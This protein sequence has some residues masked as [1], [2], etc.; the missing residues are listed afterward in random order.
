MSKQPDGVP[1]EL[2]DR[3]ED[4]GPWLWLGLPVGLTA[5][6]WLTPLLGQR[7]WKALMMG[8]SGFLEVATVVVLVAAMIVCGLLLARRR[9]LPRGTVWVVLLLGLASLFYAGEEASWGQHWLGYGT[10]RAVK[11]INK[12]EEFNLHNL[13]GRYHTLFNR[14]PRRLAEYSVAFGGV[15]LPLLLIRW[16]RRPQ[17]RKSG[18]HW[19]L[20]TLALV[21]ASLMATC[22]PIPKKIIEGFLPHLREN[23]YVQ[24]AFLQSREDFKELGLALVI[25]LYMLSLFARVRHGRAARPSWSALVPQPQPAAVSRSASRGR[26][27]EPPGATAPRR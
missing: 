14:L 2:R 10:P 27:P 8:E 22:A 26:R 11:D 15:L 21:P 23:S 6:C 25:T 1:V 24:M 9:G 20:P 5:M 4:I 12:Q 19:I 16:R 3:Q 7:R 13:N 17:A 18:W